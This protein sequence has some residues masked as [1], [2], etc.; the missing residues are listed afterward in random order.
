MTVQRSETADFDQLIA[1]MGELVD[2]CHAELMQLTE[3]A[4]AKTSPDGQ[5]SGDSCAEFRAALGA[6]H[7]RREATVRRL[8]APCIVASHVY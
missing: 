5:R 8:S 7:R 6:C 3:C 2:P 4:N 1:K